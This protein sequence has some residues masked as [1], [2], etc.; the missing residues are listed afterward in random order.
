MIAGKGWKNTALGLC[1]AS[2]VPAVSAGTF[3]EAEPNNTFAT[4]QVISDPGS[5]ST[6]INGVRSFADA[7][8]DFFRF[9]VAGPALLTI[10]ASSPDRF[11]D[12][13]MGL[14]GP[15]GSLLASNDDAG[16]GTTL[17][18]ISFNALTGGLFTIG[19]SGF[20]PGL[21]SCT[22]TV[23]SCYDTD[24]DFIFDTFVAAGGQGG[25]TG[26]AYSLTI[27]QVAQPVPE[28]ETYLLFGAGLALM[29]WLRRR[30]ASRRQAEKVS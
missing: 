30:V 29:P 28:P 10:T 22:A 7:S 6:V 9:F 14:Y 16:L 19:F 12:S 1:I 24:N 17:S 18:A 8:D 21:L 23:T 11:A 20:D 3:G 5:F 26:W 15:T 4:A 25:S 2:V 13:V 27:A